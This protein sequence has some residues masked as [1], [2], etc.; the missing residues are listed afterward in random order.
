MR[1]TVNADFPTTLCDIWL[2]IEK[3]LQK[4]SYRVFWMS[5]SPSRGKKE[6]FLGILYL[7]SASS[8]MP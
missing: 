2:G 8:D 7:S 3:K 6:Q 1:E 4:E 5:D